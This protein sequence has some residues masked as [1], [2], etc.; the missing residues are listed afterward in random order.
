MS[1]YHPCDDA[2]CA[3]WGVHINPDAADAWRAAIQI[4]ESSSPES[5]NPTSQRG[6]EAYRS[7]LVAGLKIGA[8][9]AGV[10]VPEEKP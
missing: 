3:S 7:A 1:H 6:L 10:P 4:A 2:R 8:K 9:L 5:S